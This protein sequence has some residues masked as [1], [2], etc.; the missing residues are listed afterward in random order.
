MVCQLCLKTDGRIKTA[1]KALRSSILLCVKASRGRV[2]QPGLKT[3]G[4]AVWMVHVSSL[5]RMCRDQVED[6]RIDAT[7]YVR[8][9]YP[10][11]A[12]FIVLS[13][14]GSLVF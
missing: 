9:Y 10:Y 13:P 12:I 3:G 2:S 11:L 8:P 4:G 14:M 1:R 7:S 6:G 5:W